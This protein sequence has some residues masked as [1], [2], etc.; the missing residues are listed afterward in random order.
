MVDRM[1]EAPRSP[2]ARILAAARDLLAE[3]GSGAAVRLDEIAAR[4]RTTKATLYRYFPSKAALLA[5]AAPEE[6]GQGEPPGRRRQ[7]LEAALRVI[8]HH[9][10][11][12]TTMEAIAAEAGLSPPALYWYFTSK[13]ELFLAAVD[14][15]TASIDVPALLT[16][17]PVAAP[18]VVLPALA[19]RGIV[20]WGSGS[21]LFGVFLA[22]AATHPA[23]ADALFDR[24]VGPLWATLARYLERQ[25]D[26]GAL[27]PGHPTLRVL[28]FTG[29]LAF[30]NLARRTF[31]TRLDVPDPPTAAREFADLFL[32]GVSNKRDEE[33]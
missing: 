28:A 3:R 4:A 6:A 15:L 17:T 8:P 22:E 33:P 29:M 19:G 18:Y 21:Q 24:V 31:G 13:D 25:A 11:D 2:Q 23:L 9:G 32:F 12:G 10:L 5:A 16:A 27:R 20:A 26:Q 1:T 30:Y 14:H 7:I